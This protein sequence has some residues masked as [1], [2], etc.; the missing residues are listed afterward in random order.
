MCGAQQVAGALHIEEA[1]LSLLQARHAAGQGTWQ[2]DSADSR[3]PLPH[4][5]TQQRFTHTH[6]HTH[7]RRVTFFYEMELFSSFRPLDTTKMNEVSSRIQ[8]LGL[9]GLEMGTNAITHSV[10]IK[11]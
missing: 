4:D 8:F 2:V 11:S 1:V 7:T 3:L 10:S 5:D 9:E 6:T